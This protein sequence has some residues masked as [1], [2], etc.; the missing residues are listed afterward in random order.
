MLP[1]PVLIPSLPA[2]APIV[3]RSAAKIIAGEDFAS[4]TNSHFSR[5]CLSL[6]PKQATW[7]KAHVFRG[8]GVSPAIFPISTQRNNAGGTPA[9]QQTARHAYCTV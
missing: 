9:P 8:A 2:I 3:R 6:E 7:Q 1:F 5:Q 4:G